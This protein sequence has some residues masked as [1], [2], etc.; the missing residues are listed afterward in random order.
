MSD[1]L[2]KPAPHTAAARFIA[3]KPALL[4]REF[5]QLVPELRA[6]AFTVA[7]LE[8][9][10]A[11]ARVR[12]HIAALPLGAD[13]EEAK[14]GILDE[15]ADTYG[16]AA[17]ERRAELLLRLHGFQSYAA[18]NHRALESMR[19]IFPYRRYVTAGDGRVRASHR[20]LGGLVLPADSPF[21]QTHTPPWQWGC[22]CDTVGVTEEDYADI[23]AQDAKI[24]DPAK[25]SIPTPEAIAKLENE[26]I[27]SRGLNDTHNVKTPS[28]G[29]RGTFEWDPGTLDIP[30]EELRRKYSE[31]PGGPE[32]F[33]KFEAFARSLQPEGLG[34]TLW[35]WLENPPRRATAVAVPTLPST[36]ATVA[37][38]ATTTAAAATGT[39]ADHIANHPPV[40]DA[41]TLRLRGRARQAAEDALAAIESVHGDG[42]LTPVPLVSTRRNVLG[43]YSHDTRS[44]AAIELA[45]KQTGDWPALTLAHEVGHWLDHQA[46]GTP[47]SFASHT[48]VTAPLWRGFLHA[49]QSTPTYRT[50]TA[51][52]YSHGGY[53]LTTHELFAR[54]YAQFIATESA[55]PRLLADLAR[56]RA[57]FQPWRQWPEEE[58]APIAN[59]IRAILDDKG[60]IRPKP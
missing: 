7:G 55:H 19:H 29:G 8:S 35:D 53:F 41:L 2:T 6:R 43:Y 12:S 42:L 49:V 21:W 47:G 27:V 46:L 59:A 56:V 3:G 22:R 54:A 51:L 45:L 11:I 20:A 39:L 28:Q 37:T 17:A 34:T 36:A 32:A 10:D 13:W 15:I 31:E 60:W 30:L 18:A 16:G 26:G 48:A 38:V 4:R 50:L 57:G 33:A 52:P 1:F 23:Q 14:A 25:R 9:T 5:D 58:F 40:S 24:D 44:G